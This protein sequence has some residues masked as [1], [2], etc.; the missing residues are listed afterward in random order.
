MKL[1][2]KLC[3]SEINAL[4]LELKQVREELALEKAESARQRESKRLAQAEVNK[5]HQENFDQKITIHG[6]RKQVQTMGYAMDLMHKEA[7][8]PVKG[9]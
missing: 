2:I 9:Y 4:K 8:N 5:S 3:Q 1:T 6:L 7:G